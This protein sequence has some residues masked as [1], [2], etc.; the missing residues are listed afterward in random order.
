M[1]QLYR[2]PDPRSIEDIGTWF[3]IL[4]VISIIAVFVNA[5]LVAFTG[6]FTII[7]AW[8]IRIWIFILMSSGL[9]LI[10]AFLA[11]V[12]PDVPAEVEIQL[13][14]QEFIRSRVIENIGDDDG[15]RKEH[16]RVPPK[17]LVGLFDNDPM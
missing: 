11:Y 13:K 15:P 17:Y 16:T 14:R 7:Y 8:P 10:K 12:I 1:S 4:E 2:R 9:L 5:G 3:S 6:T